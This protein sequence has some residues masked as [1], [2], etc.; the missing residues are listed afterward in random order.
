ME[1]IPTEALVVES[2]P[3]PPPRDTPELFAHPHVRATFGFGGQLVTVL[4]S[5]SGTA[6]SPIVE[7]VFLKDVANDAET[8][9]LI[10]AVSASP[11]PFVLGDTPKSLVVRFASK[12]A[13]ACRE[14]MA[15]VGD[16]EEALRKLEDE[17]LLWDF[18]VLLCQQNGV[19]VSSDVSDLLMKDGPSMVRSVPS[20][21]SASSSQDE[22]LDALRQL[23]FSGRKKDAVDMACSKGLWGHALML[24]SRMDEQTR[25][26]VVNRFTASL[27]NSDPLST[28]YTLL[29]GR[30]PSAVKPEGLPRA[31]DWKPHLAMI[32]ANRMSK[33][34]NSSIVGLGDSLLA[35]KRLHAAHLCYHL[36]NVHFGVYGNVESK[37]SLLGIDHTHLV[38]GSYPKPSDLHMMEV[39]EYAMSLSK[40]DFLMPNFQLFKFLHALKLL[41]LGFVPKAL[42]YCEQISCSAVVK[43]PHCFVPVFL[44]LLVE[45]SVRLHHL[46]CPFEV[47][48]NEY[49]SWLHQLQQV[50]ADA[51]STDYAPSILSPSPAFSSVSQSYA[52]QQQ[53]PSQPIIGLQATTTGGY[54]SVP[55]TAGGSRVESGASSKEG[56]VIN[57]KIDVSAAMRGP[58]PPSPPPT[59]TDGVASASAQNNEP[60]T[61]QPPQQQ[62]GGLVQ[63]M[64]T[65]DATQFQAGYDQSTSVVTQQQQLFGVQAPMQTVQPPFHVGSSDT[66]YGQF[67]ASADGQALNSGSGLQEPSY[68][69]S[70]VV[71]AQQYGAAAQQMI[72]MSQV[73]PEV[74]PGEEFQPR[75]ET[76]GATTSGVGEGAQMAEVAYADCKFG[77]VHVL[78]KQY[79][80]LLH[81]LYS[82]FWLITGS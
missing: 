79:V 73:P 29:L 69:H 32:L 23:L 59:D 74:G 8:Q 21:A 65:Y 70:Q 15:E 80:W 22:S 66:G 52:A 57:M 4:P 17:A 33:L 47:V 38:T 62:G 16:N 11:S 58:P 46:S 37:Y 24:S 2:T 81:I 36:A 9:S 49:P 56:S 68:A 12:E 78:Y 13:Q 53:L 67:G 54:L 41:E 25:T 6:C 5:Y 1:T 34:E 27:M 55:G 7:I 63:P 48:E 43:N 39:L 50:V 45:T 19:V 26:Y 42:K 44:H 72:T 61:D 64:Q 18:L 40:Q 82:T 14:K 76:E 20:P 60:V 3:P 28:F 75:Q 51:L 77:G 71:P 30:T 31:G 10:E 35:Q